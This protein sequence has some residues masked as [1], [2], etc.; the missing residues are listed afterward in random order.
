MWFIN[1]IRKLFGADPNPTTPAV[2]KPVPKVEEKK[3]TPVVTGSTQ[4]TWQLPAGLKKAKDYLYSKM[5]KKETDPAFNKEMSA[6]WPKYFKMSLGTIAASWAAWCG[7]MMADVYNAGGYKVP[8][9]GSLSRNWG[10]AEDYQKID[11]KNMGFPEM[12]GIWIEHNGK[13]VGGSNHVTFAKGYCAVQDLVETKKDANGVYQPILV[14]GKP[15][16][17]KNATVDGTGGNQGNKVGT[18][19]YPV[20]HICAVSWPKVEKLPP[21]I[22]KSI[23]CTSGGTGGSTR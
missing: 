19:T 6:K 15:V 22:T 5:G 23:N 16:L 3:P 17:K 14:N 1:F 4:S 11:W 13:C 12:A 8:V 10:S 21:K 2:A 20:A 18:N 7:L 9:N